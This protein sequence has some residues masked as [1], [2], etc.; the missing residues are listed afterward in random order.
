MYIHI[1]NNYMVEDKK[2]IGIFNLE[3]CKD[4]RK[5]LNNENIID[6]SN[7]RPKSFVLI[8]DKEFF[9]GY[10]SNISSIT[11]ARR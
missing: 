7:E 5:S 3:N 10:I 11:L 9:K 4:I 8:K 2:I 6:I 1:G